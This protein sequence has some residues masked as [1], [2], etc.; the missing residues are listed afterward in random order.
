MRQKLE[1]EVIEKESLKNNLSKKIS[2]FETK[3]KELSSSLKKANAELETQRIEFGKIKGDL[4]SI[5]KMEIES[6]IT[7]LY[8]NIFE[9]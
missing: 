5:K 3:N 9:N 6:T 8:V 2:T 1:K 4:E 7:T